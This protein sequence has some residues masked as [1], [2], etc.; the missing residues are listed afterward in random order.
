MVQLQVK[1]SE[2][3]QRIAYI[4]SKLDSTDVDLFSLRSEMKL[5]EGHLVRS[6]TTSPDTHTRPAWLAAC[7]HGR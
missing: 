7:M 6:S 2:L 1:E 3:N 5:L 4:V